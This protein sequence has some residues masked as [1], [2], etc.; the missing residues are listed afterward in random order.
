MNPN[1]PNPEKERDPIVCNKLYIGNLPMNADNNTVKML[2]WAHKLRYCK[3]S[4]KR[5]PSMPR[6][7]AFVD[8][9]TQQHADLAMDKLSGMPFN[10]CRLIVEPRLR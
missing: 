5:K 1:V 9:S 2:F 3:I 8:F 10:G 7:Y 6:A 4:V